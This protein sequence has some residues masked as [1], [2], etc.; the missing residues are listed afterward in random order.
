MERDRLQRTLAR[1][2]VHARVRTQSK[3]ASAR[4]RY[5]LVIEKRDTL[6]EKLDLPSRARTGCERLKKR[7]AAS[8]GTWHELR[9]ALTSNGRH[10][11]VAPRGTVTRRATRDVTCDDG[12][13]GNS[14]AFRPFDPKRSREDGPCEDYK[15]DLCVTR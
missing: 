12:R 5:S 4:T 6:L 3:R 2:H 14:P 13:T 1:P 11:P 9:S 10:V 8:P 7:T 15:G